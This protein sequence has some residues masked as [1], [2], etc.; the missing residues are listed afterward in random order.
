MDFSLCRKYKSVTVINK[1]FSGFER[2]IDRKKEDRIRYMVKGSVGGFR[3]EY[4]Q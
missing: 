4:N 2:N 3:I 1:N